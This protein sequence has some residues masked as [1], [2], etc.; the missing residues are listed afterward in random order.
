MNCYGSAAEFDDD[1]NALI[2]NGIQQDVDEL[3][4]SEEY[5]SEVNLRFGTLA[6]NFGGGILLENEER[7]IFLS[8]NN[9]VIF[10]IPVPPEQ[11]LGS[12]CTDA[13]DNSKHLLVIPN[14]L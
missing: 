12:D 11:L 2:V 5:Y 10:S 13:A 9:S 4:T 1:G 6:E 14:N 3:K 8:I 7:R